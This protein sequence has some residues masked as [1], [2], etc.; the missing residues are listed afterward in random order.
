MQGGSHVEKLWH[1][2]THTGED[3][4]SELDVEN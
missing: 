2:V 4:K 3:R 1:T